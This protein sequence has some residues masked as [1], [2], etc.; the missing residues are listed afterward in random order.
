MAIALDTGNLDSFGPGVAKLADLYQKLEDLE[1]KSTPLDQDGG[2]A[3][4]YNPPGMP[5][6]PISCGEKQGCR[7]C[8]EKANQKL[9]KLRRDFEKLRLLY[10][11]TDEFTK[12]AVAFGDGAAGSAGVGALEWSVQRGKIK[13]SFKNF[14][15]AYRNKYLELLEKLQAALQEIAAC[16]KEYFGEDD[17]YARYGFMFHSFIALHYQK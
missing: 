2:A 15:K 17:W 14:E 16:E 6:V 8:Y 10:K 13:K 7:S 3:P 12:A 9:E 5:E 1:E 4:D 11:E